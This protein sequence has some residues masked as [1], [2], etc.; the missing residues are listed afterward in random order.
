MGEYQRKKQG[1]DPLVRG[2]DPTIRIRTVIW[3]N[4]GRV[5]NFKVILKIVRKGF[6]EFFFHK[7][8]HK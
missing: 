8:I 3:G 6:G 4:T 7:K 1:P 2:T 5:I